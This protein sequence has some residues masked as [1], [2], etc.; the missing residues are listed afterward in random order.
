MHFH[1]QDLDD[2]P[3]KRHWKHGRCWWGRWHFEWVIPSW[4]NHWGI[5][6]GINSGD[7]N[8]EWTFDLGIGL[9]TL[10]VGVEAYKFHIGYWSHYQKEP[11]FIHEQRECS[12][13]FHGGAMWI[14]PWENWI[15]DYGPN[16]KWYQ[17]GFHID[18]MDILFG[19]T[20]YSEK[21]LEEGNCF[22]PMPE[23]SYEAT[24]KHVVATWT[25]R[26]WPFKKQWLR[27]HIDVPKGIPVEGK[28][29][30]S[31]DCGEDATYGITCVARTVA[32][33]I[34]TLVSSVLHDRK[35]HGGSFIHRD[36]HAVKAKI[37]KIEGEGLNTYV[38]GSGP[39]SQTSKI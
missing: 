35:R 8:N 13:K 32:D 4:T 34:G 2:G 19:R 23:G 38:K 1:W 36:L 11:I 39:V 3:I 12:V 37:T 24:Y 29:E 22:I 21:I 18:P 31:W 26:R 30:N 10:F 17:N 27:M 9:F 16:S 15:G 14:H 5:G 28:G 7:G 25:R 20:D 33:G 6:F